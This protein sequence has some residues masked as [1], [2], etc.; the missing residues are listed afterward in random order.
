MGSPG[1]SLRYPSGSVTKNAA[2]SR[3]TALPNYRSLAD[4]PLL[5]GNYRA[6]TSGFMRHKSLFRSRH[7]PV[8]KCRDEPA[9]ERFLQSVRAVLLNG[10]SNASIG[11]YRIAL[12][13]LVISQAFV[14]HTFRS[15][16]WCWVR[17]GSGSATQ[18]RNSGRRPAALYAFL[19]HRLEILLGSTGAWHAVA[20]LMLRFLH[21]VIRAKHGGF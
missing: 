15:G 8:I 14:I 18:S 3:E 9:T 21:Q 4:L 10:P 6:R 17:A 12:P 13:A 1:F 2:A 11:T 16:S 5:N 7:S 20:N 19:L